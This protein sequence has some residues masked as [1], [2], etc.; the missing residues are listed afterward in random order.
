[1]TRKTPTSEAKP[2]L[3]CS[4]CGERTVR[5]R[6]RS[7][8]GAHWC[9]KAEC[10]AKKQKFYRKR[11]IA[12]EAELAEAVRLDFIRGMVA[13]RTTCP[14]CHLVGAISGF[15]HRDWNGQPCRA[16]GASGA[17]VISIQWLDLAMPEPREYA[18]V[19]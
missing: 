7:Q 12:T 13:G 16:L 17:G 10:L 14:S 15:A 9:Q 2:L 6:R 4:G 19:D 8:T 1:M 3:E 11:A 5:P 18:D